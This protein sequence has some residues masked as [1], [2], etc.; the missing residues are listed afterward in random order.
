[1]I[2]CD[3]CKQFTW[4]PDEDIPAATRYIKTVSH[5]IWA[6]CDGHIIV[7]KSKKITKE[8]YLKYAAFK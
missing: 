8:Q 4:Y 6:L 3:I 5:G 1:M 7:S 2:E